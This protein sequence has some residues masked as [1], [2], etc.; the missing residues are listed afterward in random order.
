MF[1][2]VK[3]HLTVL[4]PLFLL[5]AFFFLYRHPPYLPLPNQE[6][7]PELPFSNDDVNATEGSYDGAC[8]CSP[9]ELQRQEPEVMDW[10]SSR[11]LRGSPTERFRGMLLYHHLMIRLSPSP[12]R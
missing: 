2:R 5:T 11:V 12:S 3:R 9:C 1:I 8:Q 6:N 4:L 7:S 10:D